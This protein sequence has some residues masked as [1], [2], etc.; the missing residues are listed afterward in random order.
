MSILEPVGDD[1]V[2]TGGKTPPIIGQIVKYHL[3]P[4]KYVPAV[5][6][7]LQPSCVELTYFYKGATHFAVANQGTNTYE[8]SY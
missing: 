4:D 5:I 1:G 7:G 6:E 3:F 8:Y 2:Q